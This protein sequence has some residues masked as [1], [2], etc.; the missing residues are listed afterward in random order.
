MNKAK[1][2]QM[3]LLDYVSAPAHEKVIP[4]TIKHL[5]MSP[6][7]DFEHELY[8]AGMEKTPY[9]GMIWANG[10]LC[11]VCSAPMVFWLPPWTCLYCNHEFDND[12][13]D[14]VCVNG[15]LGEINENSKP[16]DGYID[17][18]FC[19]DKKGG[20]QSSGRYKVSVIEK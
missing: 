4:P 15:N 9:N 14:L 1:Y 16:P 13:F 5:H 6:V 19:R 11:S 18:V 2:S 17:V 10:K 3:S 7:S 8:A 12:E 20:I